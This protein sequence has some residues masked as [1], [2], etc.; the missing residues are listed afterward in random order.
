MG[1]GAH[2][3]GWSRPRTRLRVGGARDRRGA[4][5]GGPAGW[6]LVGRPSAV[7]APKVYKT[8]SLSSFGEK[9]QSTFSP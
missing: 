2:R 4:R 1:G 6:V 5:G 3:R 9:C 7:R 8:L